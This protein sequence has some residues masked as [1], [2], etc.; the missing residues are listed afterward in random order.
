MLLAIDTST[1]NA[2]IALVNGEGAILQLTQWTSHQ[3]HS[4]ELLPSIKKILHSEHIDTKQLSGIAITTGPG[5]FSALRVGI[6]TVKGLA[7]ASNLSI[8]AVDTLECEAYPFRT[9]LIPIVA[10]IDGGRRE[11]TWALFERSLKGLKRISANKISPHEQFVSELPSSA[12][13]CGEGL[14]TNILKIKELTDQIP[15]IQ[16][17]IPYVPGIRVSSL[18]RIGYKCLISKETEDIASLQPVYIKRP[19]ITNSNS[20]S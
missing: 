13:I 18:G 15:G 5:R 2:G 1:K 6:S 3:N 8:V 19:T 20:S 10:L 14:Q 9:S 16:L 7:L 4:V 12:L 11:F 17:A